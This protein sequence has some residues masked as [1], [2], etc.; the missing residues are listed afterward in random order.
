M[1]FYFYIA[2]A[3]FAA[4]V[5]VSWAIKG[6][7]TERESVV[8]V[9]QRPSDAE[10]EARE[11]ARR[12]M[13]ARETR[14]SARNESL[15]DIRY[16]T[17]RTADAYA[18]APCGADNKKKLVE[19]LTTYAKAYLDKRSC[20]LFIFCNDDKM[21]GSAAAFSTPLDDQVRRSLEAAFSRGGISSGDFPYGTRL[22]VMAFTSDADDAPAQICVSQNRKKS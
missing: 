11:T 5:F 3:G 17:I 2:L 9:R 21:D 12:T 1:R 10:M 22:A 19:A 18:A 16:A 20:T 8:M 6:F 13:M 7:P 15:N 14:E 4:F